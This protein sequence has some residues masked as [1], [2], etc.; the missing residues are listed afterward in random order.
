MYDTS[1]NFGIFPGK[2][3]L[4][5]YSGI[6]NHLFMTEYGNENKNHVNGSEVE[7]I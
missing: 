1:L 5:S 3:P 6:Q 7:D 2:A 4:F